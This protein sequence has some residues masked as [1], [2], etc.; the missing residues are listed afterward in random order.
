MQRQAGAVS[1]RDPMPSRHPAANRHRPASGV[2]WTG[3]GRSAAD[4]GRH[5]AADLGGIKPPTSVGIKLD[6][7]A[8]IKE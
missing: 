7:A 6:R 4:L 2:R 5:P 1:H 8:S 3:R